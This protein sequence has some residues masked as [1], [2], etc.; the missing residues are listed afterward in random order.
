MRPGAGSWA[1]EGADGHV[2]ARQQ[3]P[4]DDRQHEREPEVDEVVQPLE[5]AHEIVEALGD[6]EMVAGRPVPGHERAPVAPEDLHATEAPAKAL[7]LQGGDVSGMI[8]CP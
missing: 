1:H 2:V 4:D 3:E 7:A 5:A 8:P 6:R